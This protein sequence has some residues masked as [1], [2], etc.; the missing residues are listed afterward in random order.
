V[1]IDVVPALPPEATGPAAPVPPP[2]LA[3]DD[4]PVFAPPRPPLAAPG[5]DDDDPPLQPANAQINP[6]IISARQPVFIMMAI[7]SL[8][9]RGVARRSLHAVGS[10][11][12]IGE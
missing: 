5:G 9:R 1:A 2:L 7:G 8:V 11:E 3:G 4:P 6:K 12:T 10:Q